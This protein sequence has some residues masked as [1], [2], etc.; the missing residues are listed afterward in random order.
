MTT[1][2]DLSSQTSESNGDNKASSNLKN[3]SIKTSPSLFDT[4]L[5]SVKNNQELENSENKNLELKNKNTKESIVTEQNIE[6]KADILLNEDISN[7]VEN[8]IK[9]DLDDD[10]T[11]NFEKVEKEDKELALDIK[12]DNKSSKDSNNFVNKNS[13]LDRMILEVKNSDNSQK[14]DL[15]IKLEN[16]SNN[17]EN[18]IKS[19][20]KKSQI[21]I[22]KIDKQEEQIFSKELSLDNTKELKILEDGIDNFEDS[23]NISKE[24][25]K[26][27]SV[28][29]KI[30]NQKIDKLVIENSKDE[31]IKNSTEIFIED[32]INKE[33]LKV[34]EISTDLKENEKSSLMDKLIEKNSLVAETN[35]T[36]SVILV[37]NKIEN[38]IEK[39][40]TQEVNVNGLKSLENKQSDSILAS[41]PQ[42]GLEELKK[43]RLMDTLISQNSNQNS[44]KN[45]ENS[46]KL[47]DIEV[48]SEKITNNKFVSEDISR[49]EKQLLF[50][51][52]E[53]VNILENAKSIEDIKHSAQILDLE[54]SELEVSKEITKD[55]LKNLE[56]E[57]KKSL[58]R[59]T[60]L[61]T[62]LNEKNIRSVDVRNLITNSIEASNALLENSLNIADDV[63]IDVT[64]SLTNQFSAK[65]VAARQQLGSMMSD[66]ARQMYENYKPPVTAFRININPQDMGTISVLMKHD[67]LSGLNITLS[68]SSLTTL[69]LL[70]ENQNM[71]R[72]SLVKTFSDSSSFNLDFNQGDNNSSSKEQ[73]SNKNRQNSSKDTQ[74][75]LKLKEENRDLE[76]KND[77]M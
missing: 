64:N 21:D 22:L 70:M 25:N 23:L 7:S 3:D 12:K 55:S 24:I 62:L 30:D 65:I 41:L 8:S 37:E 50:N 28:S 10:K 72:N 31:V 2:I 34:E 75:I 5:N 59:K 60:I 49:V 1:L 45:L 52:K 68:I 17:F 29:T 77:Y 71:L 18:S 38:K 9:I 67:R 61:N 53:A 11:T 35:K 42:K 63:T 14:R 76:D 56:L 69:E 47:T 15:N 51:K 74:S 48:G 33:N 16:I 32:T 27:D 26:E 44:D 13:L 40:I 39:N 46:N 66:I 19:D 58:E 6:N 43:T 54:A 57:D 4:L 36:N 20:T 73:S